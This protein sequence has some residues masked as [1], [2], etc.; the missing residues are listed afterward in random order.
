MGLDKVIDHSFSYAVGG[1]SLRSACKVSYFRGKL[2]Q[3]FAEMTKSSGAMMSV[4]LSEN[5][6]YSYLHRTRFQDLDS[7]ITVACIN[8]P[9]NVTISGDEEVIDIVKSA[10][11]SDQIFA[12][13]LNTGVAYHS[14]RMQ[15]IAREYHS[16][17]QDLSKA[18]GSLRHTLM[19]SSITGNKIPDIDVLSSADYWVSNLVEPVRFSQALSS[20]VSQSRVPIRKK[21]G[22]MHQEV[23]HDILEIG[24]HSTLKVP[25]EQILKAKGSRT[26]IQYRSVLYRQERSSV[27][28]MN[29]MGYLYTLGY[30]I[31]LHEI[32]KTSASFSSS[33]LLIDLPEYSFNHNQTYWHESRWSKSVNFRKY[34][35]LDLLG[36]STPNF[37]ALEAQWRKFFDVVETPWIGE[38]KV[39]SPLLFVL[40][41]S[42]KIV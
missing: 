1:L 15:E 42:T 25:I 18:K 34:P 30:S 7:E 32:N 6:M 21:L 2:V 10:L 9:E 8:S 19:I 20:L 24:P 33:R 27:A 28:M 4:N 39:I 22:R 40:K 12:R 14:P 11:D 17:I 29:M 26:A 41:P 13:K 23:V 36:T 5:I 37:N 35:R 31:L 38:H 16:S 3:E